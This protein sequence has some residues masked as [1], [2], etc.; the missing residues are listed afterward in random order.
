MVAL[1]RDLD[2]QPADALIPTILTALWSDLRAFDAFQRQDADWPTLLTNMTGLTP[3]ALEQAVHQ[4]GLTR[5]QAE[6]INHPA[7]QLPEAGGAADDYMQPL[8]S[9]NEH[10]PTIAHCPTQAY[11]P[12][13]L[14]CPTNS[15]YC[16]SSVC[17][18]APR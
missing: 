14:G 6:A 3:A 11:C 5:L 18:K 17:A 9:T 15:A 12:T 10:C 1:R 7:G 13:A 16:P 8:A 2:T 4:H